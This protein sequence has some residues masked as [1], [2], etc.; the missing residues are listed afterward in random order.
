MTPL[1]R[2][3]K[4]DRTWAV[5]ALVLI[6]VIGWF[7]NGLIETEILGF[8]HDDG[9]YAV[10]AKAL[11]QGQ[12]FTLLHV[13]GHPSQIKYPIMYPLLLVPVWLVNPNFPQN[14]PMMTWLTIAFGL[15]GFWFVYRFL[16]DC[17]RFPGW[18]ALLVMA[19][20]A[21]NF[22]FMYFFSMIMSEAPYFFFSFLTLYVFCRQ[23]N[24]QSILSLPTVLGLIALSTLTFHTRVLGVAL[25]AAI[26][27]WLLMRRQWKNALVYGIGSGLLTVVPWF[28]WT[29]TQ[30][31]KLTD[32]NYP[33]V[34]AYANYGLEFV[35]NYKH[36][37]PLDSL[38]MNFMNSLLEM[39]FTLV[40]NFF[41]V[42][43]A[44]EN[45]DAVQL[46]AA[47]ALFASLFLLFGYFVI[48]I[49]S[50]LFKS[51]E[52]DRFHPEAFS[53]PALYLFIYSIIIIFWNYGD[54]M[55][56]FMTVV[57]PLFWLYFFKPLLSLLRNPSGNKIKIAIGLGICAIAAILSLWTVPNSYKIVHLSRSQHWVESGKAKKL[58][59]EYK[60]AFGF[61]RDNLPKDAPMSVGSDVVFYLY[62]E[63]PAFYTFYAS[64]RR[65][66]KGYAPDSFPR[67]MASLDHYGIK[68]LVAEPHMQMRTVKAPVNL[69][70]KGLLDNFPQR[71]Q[72]IYTSP[73]K[74]ISI[75]KILPP[76][77]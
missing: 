1:F 52:K 40:P 32:L 9:V 66:R 30:T 20:V 42:Y 13:V 35:G 24:K 72:L 47:F 67:L 18:M 11:S 25:I 2:R 43:P 62:T 21:A 44:L 15:A 6:A 17:E 19:L 68:Y 5:L 28:L 70:A 3:L 73:K 31:P 63:R 34:N 49:I 4:D 33:L 37:I 26:G 77:D 7:Y 36:G 55:T 69:V 22:F 57:L 48:Q 38:T 71:F 75:Y 58:W 56:R 46:A 41:K 53:V 65:A 16:R 27:V 12:G 14:L 45:I 50:T 54:Q 61:I 51:Y 74:A 76:A 60:A 23:A 10:A 59:Q 64:L 29:K 8:T 39:M